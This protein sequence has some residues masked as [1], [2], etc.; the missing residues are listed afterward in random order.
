MSQ[1]MQT[2]RAWQPQ[3]QPACWRPHPQ[4]SHR[5]RDWGPQHISLRSLCWVRVSARI[6]APGDPIGQVHGTAIQQNVTP[7]QNPRHKDAPSPHHPMIPHPKDKG[8]RTHAHRSTHHSLTSA[9]RM[10]MRPPLDPIHHAREPQ[11]RRATEKNQKQK[12]ATPPCGTAT[13]P[14]TTVHIESRDLGSTYFEVPPIPVQNWDM[15]IP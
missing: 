3:R 14:N 9:Q 1:T 7:R 4:P 13:S 11:S 8:A 10:P 5:S 2:I 15:M 12:R 6:V